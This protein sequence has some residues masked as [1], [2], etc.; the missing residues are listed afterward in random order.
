MTKNIHEY[1]ARI[2]VWAVLL[3][4][5]IVKNWGKKGEVKIV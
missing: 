5:S 3:C 2:T 1:T 4:P